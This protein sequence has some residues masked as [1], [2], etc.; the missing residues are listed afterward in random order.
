MENTDLMI[1]ALIF[2]LGVGGFWVARHIYKHKKPDN[3]PLVCPMNFNCT[4]VVHS[5]YS[6]FL[7]VPVEIFGMIYYAVIGV[8]YLSLIFMA[9]LSTPI[10]TATLVGLSLA[11]FIFSIYL[12][13]VQIF[14]LKEGCFWCFVSAAASIAIFILSMYGGGFEIMRNFLA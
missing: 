6:K 14:I 10:F 5:D 2:I 12:I 4:A 9:T 3:K 8:S 1:Q 7:G 11:A 13:A